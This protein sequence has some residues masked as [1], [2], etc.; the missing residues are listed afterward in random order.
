M[1]GRLGRR[2]GWAGAAVAVG[3]GAA[4]AW[5]QHEPEPADGRD[6]FDT[7]PASPPP[8]ATLVQPP[9]RTTP[10][11]AAEPTPPAQS[12][13]PHERNEP[14]EAAPSSAS[15]AGSVAE[16]GAASTPGAN[17]ARLPDFFTASLAT[18]LPP[19]SLEDG[20]PQA[21]QAR[22]QAEAR[23]EEWASQVEWQVQNYLA[24]QPHNE[25]FGSPRVQCRR[26]VCRVISTTSK[27]AVARADDADW[28]GLMA[29][30][31]YESVSNEFARSAETIVYNH[32]Q[33]DRVGYVTYF[34]RK[35]PSSP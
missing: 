23:D 3:V 20:T 32:S 33:P 16:T 2:L 17:A 8:P 30:L 25:T 1:A 15:S 9:H 13:R 10:V 12:A 21:L 6:R 27:R 29:G 14:S 18:D 11:E 19:E 28:H 35:P 26:T 5:Y 22:M 31:Q 34:E 4:V 24:L 7:P